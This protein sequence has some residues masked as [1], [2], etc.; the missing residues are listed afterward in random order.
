MSLRTLFVSGKQKQRIH[1][2]T[3]GTIP[4]F[5]KMLSKRLFG[6]SYF[7]SVAL[8]I[9]GRPNGRFFL[10]EI[11][12]DLGVSFSG[13]AVVLDRLLEL[14]LIRVVEPQPPAPAV[15]RRG[16]TPRWLEIVPGAFWSAI[17]QIFQDYVEH[18]FLTAVDAATAA[19]EDRRRAAQ[20]AADARKRLAELQRG[21]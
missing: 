1:Q 21:R 19:D 5:E 12:Q 18:E 8:W 10:N 3:D 16:R 11:R 6:H 13:L 15:S 4:D 20:R 2:M 14:G 7:L 9:G 17:P